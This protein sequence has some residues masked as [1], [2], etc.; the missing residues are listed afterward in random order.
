MSKLELPGSGRLDA[1]SLRIQ[2][3]QLEEQRDNLFGDAGFLG[4]IGIRLADFTG[5]GQISSLNHQLAYT[6]KKL[7]AAEDAAT[8]RKTTQQPPRHLGKPLP[9]R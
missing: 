9:R 2:H 8:Q 4:R 3:N 7:E 6:R 5:D 1:A